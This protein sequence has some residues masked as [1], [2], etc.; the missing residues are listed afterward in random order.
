MTAQVLKFVTE[1]NDQDEA[2]HLT[3]AG[4]RTALMS[5]P[6]LP[7]PECGEDEKNCRADFLTT[8]WI[9][10][11]KLGTPTTEDEQILLDMDEAAAIM[12][13]TQCARVACEKRQRALEMDAGLPDF[14][15]HAEVVA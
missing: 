8:R 7:C 15:A 2:T 9:E 6:R 5:L 12:A 4:H 14:T 1:Y 13:V 3:P 10:R 11:I